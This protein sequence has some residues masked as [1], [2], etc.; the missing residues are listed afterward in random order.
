MPVGSHLRL[1]SALSLAASSLMVAAPARASITKGPYLQG[2]G[3]TETQIRIE[4]SPP[5]T[6]S[7]EIFS[8]ANGAK[9]SASVAHADSPNAEMHSLRVTGL[10]PATSYRFVVTAGKESAEGAF[11]T[12]AANDAKTPFSFLIYG[13]N[14]TDNDAHAAVVRQMA[15]IPSDF[16]INTGDLIEDGNE[17]ALWQRFF[18]IEGELLRKRCLFAAVGNHELHETSGANFLRYFGDDDPGA[19]GLRKLYR[20]VRWENTRF[21]FLNGMDTFNTS[22]ERRWLDGELSKSDAEPNLTWRIV[23]LHQG[24]WSSG[25]HG[26]NPRLWDAGGVDVLRAH[27]VD[28]I[29]SG[30]DH[31]YE[32]GDSNGMKYVVSGGGG[33]P[34][35]AVGKKL[36]TTRKAE[37]TLH[38]IETKI[39]GD[40]FVMTV[41]RGDGSLLEN[42]G[43]VKGAVW[44]CDS[45]PKVAAAA[46]DASIMDP[47]SPQNNDNS[48]PAQTTTSRCGCELVGSNADNFAAPYLVLLAVPLLRR[49]KHSYA[50]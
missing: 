9:T 2:L 46:S 48:S 28:L 11:T 32:R 39:E 40:K 47:K 14:R 30:H 15:Q 42:C 29:V 13:D 23:V 5:T 25:P 26:N 17:P 4:L 49:R 18:D 19:A 31:I 38:F 22:D 16:L 41:R 12:A 20:T 37:S 36:P 33:A 7:V 44:D 34:L 10:T 8:L 6:A 1:F 24:A 45:N 3:A 43:F 50:D 21:F 35:Y 27:K